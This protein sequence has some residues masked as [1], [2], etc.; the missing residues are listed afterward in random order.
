MGGTNFQ[1]G[2]LTFVIKW[3]LA[4]EES[5]FGA[6]QT[7]EQTVHREITQLEN[8][9]DGILPCLVTPFRDVCVCNL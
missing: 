7:L 3:F 5:W 1:I 8:L 4:R 9:T 6:A 2:A